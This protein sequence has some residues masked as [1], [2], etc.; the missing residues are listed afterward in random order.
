MSLFFAT[1]HTELA[2]TCQFFSCFIFFF[3]VCPTC[4]GFASFNKS[5]FKT[6]AYITFSSAIPS[7]QWFNPRTANWT[8]ITQL[9]SVN[10][11]SRFLLLC[12]FFGAGGFEDV[13]VDVGAVARG[14]KWNVK[15]SHEA[16]RPARRNTPEHVILGTY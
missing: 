15:R 1:I 6:H 4:S 13:V 5:A 7:F 3:P 14:H 8:T 12:R 16:M 2:C 11:A 10:L 9:N